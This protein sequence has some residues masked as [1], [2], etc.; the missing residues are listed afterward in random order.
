MQHFGNYL[1]EQ[2][3]LLNTVPTVHEFIWQ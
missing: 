3:E 2:S 1:K